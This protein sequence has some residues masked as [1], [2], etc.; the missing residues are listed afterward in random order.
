MQQKGVFAVESKI[1]YLT[2]LSSGCNL[3]QQKEFL[4]RITTLIIP[5]YG[6]LSHSHQKCAASN[7]PL[8][9]L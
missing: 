7:L 6:L 4:H 8:I 9:Q 2:L 5:D 1:N 3:M